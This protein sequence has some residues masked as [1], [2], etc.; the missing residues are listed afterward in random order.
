MKAPFTLIVMGLLC[1]CASKTVAPTSTATTLYQDNSFAVKAPI[2]AD[3]HRIGDSA[4]VSDVTVYRVG[5]PDASAT[6]SVKVGPLSTD[7]SQSVWSQFTGAF[8][9]AKRNEYTK[10][11]QGKEM[12]VVTSV[13]PA[14]NNAP[15]SYYEN[16]LI[17]KDTHWCIMTLEVK[18]NEQ[19][20]NEL[21]HTL[22][23]DVMF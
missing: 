12:A 11:A 13:L 16:I 5:A 4:R 14:A 18:S 19:R 3:W 23:H 10:N 8:Q 15:A 6:L 21:S 7:N 20:F 17:K 9:T 1:S 22:E 2:P